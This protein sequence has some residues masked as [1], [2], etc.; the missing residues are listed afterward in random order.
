M[1]LADGGAVATPLP[2]PKGA[3]GTATGIGLDPTGL[4]LV[5]GTVT[6][7]GGLDHAVVWREEV[8]GD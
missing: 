4:R 6:G 1:D 2:L 3:A 8:A 7:P 5:A